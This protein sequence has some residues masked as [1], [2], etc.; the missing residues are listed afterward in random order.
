MPRHVCMA[1]LLASRPSEWQMPPRQLEPSKSHGSTVDITLLYIYILLL[2]YIYMIFPSRSSHLQTSSDLL[3]TLFTLFT[4][5]PVSFDSWES[6]LRSRS[7]SPGGLEINAA[8]EGA[9]DT[10]SKDFKTLPKGIET[11]HIYSSLFNSFQFYSYLISY[12]PTKKTC[13]ACATGALGAC[14]AVLRLWMACTGCHSSTPRE[15]VSVGW[16]SAPC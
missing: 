3:H 5:R 7:A 12:L 16:A 15:F 8:T 9:V 10:T 4:V 2:Y 6:R 13:A 11:T 14:T 1:P